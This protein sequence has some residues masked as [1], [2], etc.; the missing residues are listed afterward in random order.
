M[1]I[2]LNQSQLVR[3]NTHVSG[4]WTSGCPY[5]AE[6]TRPLRRHNFVGGDDVGGGVSCFCLCGGGGA[7]LLAA[8]PVLGGVFLKF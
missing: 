3:I 6:L 8:A 1:G 2:N 4:N 7:I 5:Q